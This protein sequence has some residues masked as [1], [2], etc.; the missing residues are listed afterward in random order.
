[1]GE[2]IPVVKGLTLWAIRRE[3]RRLFS[4]GHSDVSLLVE[5]YEC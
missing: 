4:M 1:M 5:R 2:F 3:I